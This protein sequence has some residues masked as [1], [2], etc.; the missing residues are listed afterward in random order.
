MDPRK[1]PGEIREKIL[2]LV[3]VEDRPIRLSKH[4]LYQPNL[5]II[6][7]CRQM[8]REGRAVFYGQNTFE[9]TP[10]ICNE[11]FYHYFGNV[12]DALPIALPIHFLQRVKI[13]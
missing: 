12:P 5:G 9:I 4:H 13:C 2:K 1:F 7:T 6:E 11:A 3:L 8:Q 10:D